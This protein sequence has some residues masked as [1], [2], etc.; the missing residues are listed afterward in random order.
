MTG[1]PLTM[2]SSLFRLSSQ[3]T[4]EPGR[5]R[6]WIAG[7]YRLWCPFVCVL[8]LF[9][10]SPRQAA[11]QVFDPDLRII[12]PR[13]EIVEEEGMLLFPGP[14]AG[15]QIVSVY[16]RGQD[17]M[18]IHLVPHLQK[19]LE[20]T[21]EQIAEL[22]RLRTAAL[23]EYNAVVARGR[24]REP[25][26]TAEQ[27]ESELKPLIT[28]F[29]E[30]TMAVLIPD[31]VKALRDFGTFI[32]V[33]R[34]GF[35]RALRLGVMTGGMIERDQESILHRLPEVREQFLARARALER[36]AIA[37]LIADLP[38]EKQQQVLHMYDLYPKS[39]VPDFRVLLIDQDCPSCS[40]PAGR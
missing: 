16:G 36:E 2:Q 14:D 15:S 18:Q 1:S 32:L 29:R 35:A 8:S 28:R 25:R 33:C 31:Q 3:F 27:V 24:G 26:P 20:L 40:I 5:T 19:F 12:T 39:Y 7:A 30:Q 37:A 10:I 22:S 17:I 34:E 11:A 13:V 6:R 21:P 9:A 23:E 38:Q 4:E